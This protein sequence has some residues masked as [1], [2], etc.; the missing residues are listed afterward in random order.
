MFKPNKK[1][2]KVVGPNPI[3]S[4]LQPSQHSVQLV[5]SSSKHDFFQ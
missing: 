2:N 4:L 5:I 3:P 1:G